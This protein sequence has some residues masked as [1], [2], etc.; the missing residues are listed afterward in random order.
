MI[1]KQILALPVLA[2]AIAEPTYAVTTAVASGFNV[3]LA[4]AGATPGATRDFTFDQAGLTANFA[5]V[6]GG[7]QL[8]VTGTGPGV[9]ATPNYVANSIPASQ[10]YTVAASVYNLTANFTSVGV[11]TGGSLIISGTP[12]GSPTGANSYTNYASGSTYNLLTESLTGFGYNASQA[13]IGF[14]TDWS[15]STPSWGTQNVFTGNAIGTSNGDATYLFNQGGL[16]T[17][18]GPLSALI[19]EF[20]TGNFQPLTINGNIESIAAVPLPLP[21]VLFGTGLT[22]LMGLGRQRRNQATSI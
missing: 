17:G 2:L 21:A 19:N 10:I 3:N 18:E 14:Q 22:A 16:G 12:S 11:F 6:S 1:Y 15:K 13:A 8:T 4:T 20:A 7:Y 9:F 5:G